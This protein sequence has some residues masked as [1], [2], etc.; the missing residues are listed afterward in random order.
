MDRQTGTIP[1]TDVPPATNAPARMYSA[2]VEGL[3][4]IPASHD[5][6][7]SSIIVP[8]ANSTREIATLETAMQ[9]LAL[10]ARH[11]VALELA[12]SATSRQFL[13]RATSEMAQRHLADQVQA[14]YPQATI[15]PVTA[16]DDPLVMRNAEA[17]SVV[18]LRAGAAAYLPLRNWRERELL[19]EGADPLLGL[20]AVFNHLPAGMR[21]V[22]QLALLPASPTWSHAYRRKA[23]EH[24]LEPERLRTRRELGGQSSGPGTVQLIG[25]GV[26][27]ALLLVWWRFQHQL[28]AR[29]PPWLLHAGMAILHG[30]TPQLTSAELAT[31]AVTG[32]GVLVACFCLAFGALQ[33]KTHLG[34][35]PIYDMRLV[36]EKTARPAY[37]VR[38]RLFVFAPVPVYLRHS[39]IAS[40]TSA[41]TSGDRTVKGAHCWLSFVEYC[42]CWRVNRAERQRFWQERDEVLKHLS[43]AYRQYHTAS[44]GY[45]IPQHLSAA[46]AL[47]LLEPCTRRRFFT[48]RCGWDADLHRSAHLLSVADVA[49]LWHLPQANDL[50]DLPYMERGRARTLL[51]PVL[52]TQG[53]GTRIGT[54]SHAGHCVPV[55]LPDE[56]LRHNLL[57]VASTGKG[58]ST[59]FQH[60]AGAIFA[61]RATTGAGGSAHGDT[62]EGEGTGHAPGC[63][64]AFI[65]PHGDVI[66]ALLGRIPAHERD[67]VVLVDLANAEYPVGLNP[68]DMT[69]RDRDK[70]VDNLITLAEHLWESSYGSRTENVLEYALKTL[71]DVNER[72]IES[73]PQQGPDRQYTLLDVVPLLRQHS[74]R[75]ALFEQVRDEM[76][77]DWWQHYY[78]PMDAHQQREVT[79]SVITKLSKFASSRRARRILGQ[80]RSTV[81]LNAIIRAGQILLVSTA[82]GVVGTD[83]SELIG[84]VLLGLFESA[85][86]EQ[87]S[88]PPEER[89]R[90]LVLI[91]EFQV[92]RGAN[93][94]MML[95]ELR[96]YGGSFGLATQSLSYLD[97]LDRTLRS[98]VLANIDHLFAFHM[99]GEDARLLHELDG[100]VEDDITNLDDF[101][102]YVKLSLGGRR[103][104]VFSLNLDAPPGSDEEV[105]TAI[106]QRSQQRDTRPVGVVDALIQQSRI[107]QQH[108]S[109]TPRASRGR[110]KET[111]LMGE[112]QE[113]QADDATASN[114]AAPA[115]GATR[116][117]RKRGGSSRSREAATMPV[118]YRHIIYDEEASASVTD[119]EEQAEEPTDDG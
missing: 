76:L 108:P 95:A 100:I 71:A 117:R 53:N 40:V 87:A 73:D 85:L 59:L 55:F 17:V 37:R 7:L 109:S 49:A 63:S 30:T 1:T 58:K 27:V 44:G 57:A 86:A 47:R 110:R 106:S 114:G 97:R 52:V 69:G 28:A 21:V 79:S 9:G 98:T 41:G 20:L 66:H 34:G 36:G 77:L 51:A 6:L 23:V 64:L 101:Q 81:D 11:P 2:S 68:L 70:A 8:R 118:T 22:V 56:C 119:H 111:Q 31:L 105:A 78:E 102:C 94:Q 89:R 12:A 112:P 74:F 29:I 82:S 16:G 38:L 24:P 10:D 91:D 26:L 99:A 116:K 90:Y 19:Q 84:I 25:M 67:N 3:V 4:K 83:L 60:L 33:I 13:V 93:Y 43:A 62:S 48:R 107:R 72:L 104:P 115:G 65:E 61:A 103:L 42:R 5:G 113:P 14:R 18:E 39:S 46:Q 54:S 45:F 80:P 50:A 15:Q 88:M 32:S 75:H 35:S 96:K 92:Y